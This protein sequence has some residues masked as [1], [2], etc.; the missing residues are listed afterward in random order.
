M[1]GKA[2]MIYPISYQVSGLVSIIN[3]VAIVLNSEH[4]N[5]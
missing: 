3:K 1:K 5:I 2:G 4:M